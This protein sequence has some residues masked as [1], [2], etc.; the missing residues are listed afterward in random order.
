MDEVDRLQ[1]LSLVSKVCADLEN[2]IGVN[3]KVRAAIMARGRAGM[4]AAAGP[5]GA[6]LGAFEAR[7][8][9]RGVAPPCDAICLLSLAHGVRRG[10]ARVRGCEAAAC[11]RSDPP[12]SAQDL[13]EFVVDLGQKAGNEADFKAALDKNGAD[14][15]MHLVEALYATIQRMLPKVRGPCP[16]ALAALTPGAHSR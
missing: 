14:F 6:V 8:C 15:E 12:P 16:A 11:V 5:G 1:Y 7:T 13:A 2:H 3:D 4:S 10:A 9:A